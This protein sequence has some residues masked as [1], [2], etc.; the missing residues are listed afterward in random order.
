MRSARLAAQLGR[1]SRPQWHQTLF[2]QQGLPDHDPYR[3]ILSLLSGPCTAVP[4]RLAAS[5]PA[6]QEAKAPAA[7][8]RPAAAEGEKVPVAT[9]AVSD[10]SSLRPQNGSE[11]K[12]SLHKLYTE[13]RASVAIRL[14]E[15]YL[16]WLRSVRG[17]PDADLDKLRPDHDGWELYAYF[18][19][20]VN[21]PSG[22]LREGLRGMQSEWGLQPTLKLYNMVLR[23]CADQRTRAGAHDA[24]AVLQELQASEL[25]PD[26]AS[27]GWAIRSCIQQLELALAVRLMEM[28]LSHMPVSELPR[29][30]Q[31]HVG[32]LLSQ[33]LPLCA[34]TRRMEDC[35]WLLSQMALLR[36]HAPSA[37]LQE[38]LHYAVEAHRPDAVRSALQAMSARRRKVSVA[39]VYGPHPSLV[40]LPLKTDEGTLLAALNCVA[41]S[42]DAETAQLAWDMLVTSLRIPS[43]PPQGMIALVS[44][45][46]ADEQLYIQAGA[47]SPQQHSGGEDGTEEAAP[48][49][50][51][52]KAGTTAPNDRWSTHESWGA[53]AQAQSQRRGRPLGFETGLPQSNGAASATEAMGPQIATS[54]PADLESVAEYLPN[55]SIPE[56]FPSNHYPIPA[57]YQAVIHTFAVACQFRRMFEMMGELERAYPDEPTLISPFQGLSIVRKQVAWGA[58]RM[59]DAWYALEAMHKEGAPVTSSMAAGVVAGCAMAGDMLRTRETLEALPTLA[60]QPNTS[61]MNGL[62]SGLLTSDDRGTIPQVFEDMQAAGIKP[63]IVSHELLVRAHIALLDVP[64]MMAALD[65]MQQAGFLPPM[66]LLEACIARGE[67]EGRLDAVE[68]I[69]AMPALRRLRTIGNIPKLRRWK[70]EGGLEALTASPNFKSRKPTPFFKHIGGWQND[71]GQ[72]DVPNMPFWPSDEDSDSSVQEQTG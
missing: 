62:I 45:R 53:W 70:N 58:K 63:D 72:L 34:Q 35:M 68:Q 27:Y 55:L 4:S 26:L 59:D 11:L 20:R 32:L 71:A 43:T 42:G 29:P 28:L 51:T 41:P 25:Q 22:V 30:D 15:D 64:A 67:R 69:E 57:S 54:T 10:D 31:E 2:A 6:S 33:L 46:L 12:K 7:T 13:K 36:R 39:G 17:A 14:F 1:L 56:A 44:G 18:L 52:V 50:R 65:N 38:V 3:E 23:H 49:T 47:S 60:L 37:A 16:S 19:M 61:C 21:A 9:N 48:S 40:K 8:Q 5:V 24:A 66:S